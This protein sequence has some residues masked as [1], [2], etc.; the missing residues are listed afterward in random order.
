MQLGTHIIRTRASM[1]KVRLGRDDP[2]G[3]R[4]PSLSTEYFFTV[5][6]QKKISKLQMF[7]FQKITIRSIYNKFIIHKNMIIFYS[8]IK[9]YSGWVPTSNSTKL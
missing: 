3:F 6:I 4:A 7:T 2:I 8:L 9:R 5:F 1:D